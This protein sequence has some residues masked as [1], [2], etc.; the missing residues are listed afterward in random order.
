[1]AIRLQEMA[2]TISCIAIAT[3]VLGI[4]ARLSSFAA[5]LAFLAMNAVLIALDLSIPNGG[6]RLRSLAQKGACF[7]SAR[8]YRIDLFAARYFEAAVYID[9]ALALC[10]R[11]PNLRR[12]GIEG[13]KPD[14]VRAVHAHVQNMRSYGN[15]TIKSPP[16]EPV[17]FDLADLSS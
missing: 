14:G 5:L 11:S 9:G 7:P 8:C 13:P 4:L 3:G 6:A 16:A 15:G 2:L 12:V 17:S 10:S 1:M